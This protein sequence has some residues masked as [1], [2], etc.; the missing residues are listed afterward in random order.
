MT[1]TKAFLLVASKLKV[2]PMYLED[3]WHKDEGGRDKHILV[4]LGLSDSQNEL[5]MSRRA[6]N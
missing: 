3:M 2:I 1:K 4:D 5:V 6:Y